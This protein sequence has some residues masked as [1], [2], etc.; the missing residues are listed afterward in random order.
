[1]R[2]AGYPITKGTRWIA[3]LF[4]Y[5]EGYGYG[6]FLNEQRG[7]GE[8]EEEVRGEREVGG[9]GE[10]KVRPSGDIEGGYVVYRQTVELANLLERNDYEEEE[11]E[12][13]G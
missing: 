13:G 6:E 1:M 8:E 2:H 9:R 3:V 7:K 4:C 12:E 10:G 5:V 11:E